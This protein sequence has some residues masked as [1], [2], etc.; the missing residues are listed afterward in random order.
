MCFNFA[1]ISSGCV[2]TRQIPSSARKTC[3][4]FPFLSVT[5]SEYGFAGGNGNSR[6]RRMNATNIP[7]NAK[8]SQRKSFLRIIN[9]QKV[10]VYRK[11]QKHKIPSSLLQ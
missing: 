11:K 10:T 9:L 8:T 2:R 3:N 6:L 5:T 1:G 4:N 7:H